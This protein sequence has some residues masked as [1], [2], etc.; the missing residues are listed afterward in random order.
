MGRPTSTPKRC[1][2]SPF[3]W[4]LKKREILMLAHDA[5]AEEAKEKEPRAD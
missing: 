4:I 1:I 3:R 5:Q 2:G